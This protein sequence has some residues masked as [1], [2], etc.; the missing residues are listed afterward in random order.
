MYPK[1][2]AGTVR[3]ITGSKSNTLRASLGS[4]MGLAGSRAPHT[5]GSG[6]RLEPAASCAMADTLPPANS[7]LAVRNCR[8][9]RRVVPRSDRGDMAWFPRLATAS[10]MVADATRNF[11]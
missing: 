9:L 2:A 3:I 1:C 11:D 10:P 5:I 6:N 4:P 7:G 8:N